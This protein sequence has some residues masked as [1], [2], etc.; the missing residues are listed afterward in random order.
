MVARSDP[1]PTRQAEEEDELYP[2]A[3]FLSHTSLAHAHK[4][5]S[6]MSHAQQGSSLFIDEAQDLIESPIK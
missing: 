5:G 3:L 4:H 1:P 6:H 2:K